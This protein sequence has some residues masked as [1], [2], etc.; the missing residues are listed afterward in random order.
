MIQNL[1]TI[2]NH[3]TSQWLNLSFHQAKSSK[4]YNSGLYLEPGRNGDGDEAQHHADDD[5]K[6][7]DI[8]D[9]FAATEL[10]ATVA[11][12]TTHGSTPNE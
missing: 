5:Q 10:A 4:P 7:E 9:L 1:K 6:A 11:A 2:L 3:L 12:V 8:E